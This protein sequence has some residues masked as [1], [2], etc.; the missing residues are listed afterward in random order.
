MKKLSLLVLVLF[1]SGCMHAG[2]VKTEKPAPKA[3]LSAA[4]LSQVV[5]KG[6]TSKEELMAK[7]GIPNG[8]VKH[9]Y[10]VPKITAPGFNKVVPPNL[11]AV[12]T[13]NYWEGRP[14]HGGDRQ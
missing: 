3:A 10:H 1:S 13:W 5:V 14:R 11:M 8:I 9:P 6:K 12:E 7:L 4:L 2:S